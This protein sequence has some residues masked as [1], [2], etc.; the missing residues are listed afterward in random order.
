MLKIASIVWSLAFT[1]LAGVFVTATLLI[2]ACK[3]Q[4]ALWISTAA[5]S[6]AVIAAPLA[7]GVA[8]FL[9]DEVV[10]WKAPGKQ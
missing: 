10:E 7:W 5:V 4:L 9:H 8:R 3:G 6:A 1:V 2:P